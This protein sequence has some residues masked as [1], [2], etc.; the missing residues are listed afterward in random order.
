MELSHMQRS[1]ALTCTSAGCTRYALQ[2]RTYLVI[3]ITWG[4]QNQL[5]EMAISWELQ[6]S[7]PIHLSYPP[8]PP[9]QSA[10]H[11]AEYI[12][13]GQCAA[14]PRVILMRGLYSLRY[15]LILRGSGGSPGSRSPNMSYEC[16]KT[17]NLS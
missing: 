15:A 9:T 10:E 13:Q 7:C 11:G 4:S 16:F 1:A 5:D 8:R 14:L 17:Q 12:S 3:L 6:T 2:Q